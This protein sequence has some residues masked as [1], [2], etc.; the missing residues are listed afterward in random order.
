MDKKSLIKRLNWFFSLELNQVDLYKAQS[1]AFAE[2]Y[3]GLVFERLSQIEQGHVDNIGAKIKELG[4]NPTVIG[5]VISPILGHTAGTV[6]GKMSLAEVLKI[7]TMIEQKAMKDYKSLI[8]ELKES[9]YGSKE[10]ITLLQQNFIDENLHTEWFKTKLSE[11]Q[12][13]EFSLQPL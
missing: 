12:T 11:L 13:C 9:L 4:A 2:E 3:A 7:N 10:L 8:N 6:I 1:K 5:D